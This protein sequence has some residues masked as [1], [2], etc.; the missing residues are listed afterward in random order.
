MEIQRAVTELRFISWGNS[1]RFYKSIPKF[2][3]HNPSLWLRT[4]MWLWRKEIPTEVQKNLSQQ[5]FS[6]HY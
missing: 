4:S 6:K 2:T 1:N 3:R 5:K